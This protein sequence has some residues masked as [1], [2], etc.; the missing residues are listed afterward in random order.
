MTLTLERYIKPDRERTRLYPVVEGVSEETSA[1]MQSMRVKKL[2]L[3]NGVGNSILN[4]WQNPESV[5]LLIWQVVLRVTDAS[6]NACT[7]DV[8]VTDDISN[9]GDT[10]LDGS[11]LNSTGI[12]GIITSLNDAAIGGNSTNLPHIM[13]E[14]DGTNQYITVYEASGNAVT[15]F[16]GEI[17][18]FYIPLGASTSGSLVEGIVTEPR[19][20]PRRVQIGQR[21]SEESLALSK[22]VCCKVLNSDDWVT[23]A[24]SGNTV[25][26][27]WQNPESKPILILFCVLNVTD[28]SANAC[29]INVDA[30]ANSG[31]NADTIFAAHALNATGIFSSLEIA[32]GN[33]NERPHIMDAKGGANDYLTIYE[34]ANQDVTSFVAKLYIFYTVLNV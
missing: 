32:A 28:A 12:N 5:K 20:S 2:T 11:V 10:I 26:A 33:Q 13:D 25:L 8:D 3:T 30:V 24:S 27:Y 21:C 4:Y 17:L 29:T 9:H 6:A 16:A 14:K 7:V 34:A 22:P 19:S 18:I 1:L 23:G 31:A 15:D